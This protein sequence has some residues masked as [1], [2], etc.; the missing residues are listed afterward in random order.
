MV[1]GRILQ[2][3]ELVHGMVG[4]IDL[5]VDTDLPTH[6]EIQM[7]EIL[8]AATPTTGILRRSTRRVDPSVEVQLGIVATHLSGAKNL[9]R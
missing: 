9:V 8:R 6:M 4:S 5:A 2:V 3:E 7:V 1:L